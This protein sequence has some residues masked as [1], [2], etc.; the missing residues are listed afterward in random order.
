MLDRYFIIKAR[1][2]AAL[3][4]LRSMRSRAKGDAVQATAQCLAAIEQIREVFRVAV[5]GAVGSGKSTFVDVV[6]LET[7]GRIRLDA[8]AISG[9]S[10]CSMLIKPPLDQTDAIVCVIDA[11]EPWAAVPWHFVRMVPRELYAKLLFVVLRSD[12]RSEVELQPVIVHID[13]QLFQCTGQRFV[14]VPCSAKLARL[15]NGGGLDSAGLRAQSR[16]DRL[17]DALGSVVAASTGCFDSL[18]QA[19]AAGAAAVTALERKWERWRW[20]CRKA[21]P[22]TAELRNSG[23]A[24]WNRF[25]PG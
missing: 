18:R 22:S 10:E 24:C 4:A 23:R 13:E 21:M 12:L 1:L 9:K 2:K 19:V 17:S 8:V 11:S 3:P 16:I 14:V 5:V 7:D 6:K 25:H 20:R 15:A